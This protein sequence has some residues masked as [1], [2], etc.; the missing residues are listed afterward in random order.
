NGDQDAEAYLVAL[1]KHT[2]AE[3][4]RAD[5]PSRTRSYCTP[6]LVRLPSR[7]DVTQ[8]V[9]SGSKCVAGYDA[10][11]GRQLWVVDGPTEQDVASLVYADDLLFMT[12]GYPEFHLMGIRPGGSGNITRTPYVAWHLDHRA[13]QRGKLASYVP[14]PLAYGGHFFVVSDVGYLSCLE[15][16][17]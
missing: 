13:N 10:D 3:R 4:W 11:S 15:A 17:T 5:R 6:L 12:G 8:L 1:D 2:G 16:Q 9:L 14:S 7:P